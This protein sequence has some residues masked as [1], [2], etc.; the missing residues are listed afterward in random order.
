MACHKHRIEQLASQAE[1]RGSFGIIF[2]EVEDLRVNVGR[3]CGEGKRYETVV[4]IEQPTTQ[5]D[6]LLFFSSEAADTTS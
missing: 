1:T 5:G 3:E 6:S 2:E 4:S